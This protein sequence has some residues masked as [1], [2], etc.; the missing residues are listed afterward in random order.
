MMKPAHATDGTYCPLWRKP[1]S[2]VCHTCAWYIQV[3]GKNPQTGQDINE[4]NCS[5][6]FMPLLQ[7]ETTKSER[8][9]TATVQELRNEVGKANDS[10]MANALM[11]LNRQVA[12]LA[13]QSA[14][15][16]APPPVAPKLLE[17]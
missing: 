10:G 14:A 17:N 8:E 2:K 3:I 6:T 9:T 4:W 12:V 5:I 1:R 13:E 11:G 7:I 15:A 16:L